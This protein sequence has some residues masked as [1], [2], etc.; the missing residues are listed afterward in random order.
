MSYNNQTDPKAK[1]FNLSQSLF[2]LQLS[3]TYNNDSHNNET[4]APNSTSSVAVFNIVVDNVDNNSLV[5][6]TQNQTDGQQII[7]KQTIYIV[8]SSLI[9]GFLVLSTVIGNVFVIAAIL[10]ERNLRTV[11]NYLVLSLAVADLMVACLVMPLGAV[12]EVIQQWT[13]GRVLCELWTLADVLCCTAS[14]LHLLAIA[15]VS[16]VPIHKFNYSVRLSSRAFV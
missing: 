6:V 11:G 1:L 3:L 13:M 2:A 7:S 14:I 4:L 5:T 16:T 10:L 8:L 9:L 15:M 12:T